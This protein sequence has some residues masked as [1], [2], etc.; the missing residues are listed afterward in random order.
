MGCCSSKP[1][2]AKAPAPQK[3]TE[4]PKQGASQQKPVVKEEEDDQTKVTRLL[5]KHNLDED[6]KLGSGY[7][8]SLDL[9]NNKKGTHDFLAESKGAKIDKLKKVSLSLIYCL[10]LCGLYVELKQG[11]PD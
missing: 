10:A 9:R 11:W 4:P 8:M 5:K 6:P 1:K 7:T 3:K 2:E